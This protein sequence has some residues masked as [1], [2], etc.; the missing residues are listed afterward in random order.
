MVSKKDTY[1][2]MIEAG[3]DF[4]KVLGLTDKDIE[5]QISKIT[6]Q[7]VKHGEGCRHSALYCP[8]CNQDMY[9]FKELK[10]RCCPHCGQRLI[11]E[12][13]VAK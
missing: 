1:S 3:K 4:K 5:K 6:P 9:L 2:N 8:T 13:K 11:W 12:E 7:K 10:V